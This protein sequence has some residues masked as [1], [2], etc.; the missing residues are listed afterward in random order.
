MEDLGLCA[1]ADA[2]GLKADALDEEKV[3]TLYRR[4]QFANQT[5]EV[6]GGKL[7]ALDCAV[8]DRIKQAQDAVCE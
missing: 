5:D 8:K 4:A 3:K 1:F 6:Y 2:F 7:A